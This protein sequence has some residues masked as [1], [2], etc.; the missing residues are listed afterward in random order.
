[1]I[2]PITESQSNGIED[3]RFVASRRRQ[4]D[5]LC[6]LHRYSAAIRSELIE[7]TISCRPHD[8]AEGRGGEQQGMACV[9]RKIDGRFAMIG[10]QDNENLYLM[11]S[12]DST[13][14]TAAKRSCGL[15]SPGSCADRHLRSPIELDEGGCC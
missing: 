10:R 11:R 3:A 9:P 5:L 12:D 14:G 8:P 6:D 7:T 13:H 2:Y 15:S 1:V 4:D